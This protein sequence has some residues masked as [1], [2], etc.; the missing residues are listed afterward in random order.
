MFV[1]KNNNARLTLVN[2]QCNM[3]FMNIFGVFLGYYIASASFNN[4]K[5][6]ITFK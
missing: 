5:R 2:R 1:I 4:G 6:Y 3:D